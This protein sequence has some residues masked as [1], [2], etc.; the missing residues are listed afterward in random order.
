MPLNEFQSVAQPFLRLE[1]LLVPPPLPAM[2]ALLMVLG[3]LHLSRRGTRWLGGSTAAPVD[4]AAAFVLTTGLLAA[5]VHAL[6]WGGYASIPA[7]RLGG[8]VLAA[9][10]VVELSSWRLQGVKSV[11]RKY[12]NEASFAERCAFVLASVTVLGLFAAVL[13]PATDAD[14]LDYHLGVPL[15]WLRHGGSY[16]RP[17]W[18]TAR[19]VGLGESLNML[20]LAAGTDGL[21]AAFQAAG[22]VVALAAVTAFAKTRADRLFAGLLVVA[23]P[24]VA[25]LITAQKPQLLPAAALTVALVMLVQRFQRFDAATALLAF[26]CAAFA[27]ASKHSFLLTG[28]VVVCVGLVVGARAHRLRLALLALTGCIAILAMPVFARNFVFYGDPLSPLL[29]RWRPGSDPVLVLFANHLRAEGGPVTLARVA[30]L[31][32]DLT[33]SLHPRYVHEVLGI[34]VFGFLLA[35]R[36]RGPARAL[37]LAALAAFV[38]LVASSPLKPRYFLEPYLWCAAAAVAAP[39]RPYKSF[40]LKALTVQAVLA[41]GIAVYLGVVLFP[42]ALTH[43]GRE[44]VMTL[45]APGY[46]EAKWLDATLPPDA[47]VLEEF[48]Y[49]ALLPRPFIVGEKPSFALRDQ[50]L[51]FVGDR[52]LMTDVP[53]WKQQLTGFL[54]RKRVTVLITEYPVKSPPSLW[55]TTH[56]GTPLAGPAKFQNAARSPFNRGDLTGWIVMRL[57]MN[58]PVSQLEPG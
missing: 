29:E 52:F 53:N 55:L 9:L 21:G 6:A 16:A 49:R 56:Y 26:G 42:G 35:L 20:G 58:V 23:C 15:D 48:R 8:W 27:M 25:T 13:G 46:A 7:L 45:M 19:Y 2:L 51:A 14:S 22:L 18:F 38:L 12:F 40:F 4:R 50:F 37:L 41:A 17:E 36:G 3:T 31:P 57:N 5:L 43:A 10:G 34:G 47:V 30:R 54:K 24:V 28:G 32:W 33:V 44:H 1:D 39:I 11:L